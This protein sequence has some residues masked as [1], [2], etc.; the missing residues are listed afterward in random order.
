MSRCNFDGWLDM[1]GEVP[2]CLSVQTTV[3]H[4]AELIVAQTVANAHS[5]IVNFPVA[6]SRMTRL[7]NLQTH[8]VWRVSVFSRPYLNNSRAVVVVVVRPSSVTD[9]LWLNAAVAYW[10]SNDIYI[11][12]LG[13]FWRSAILATAG[14]LVLFL[15]LFFVCFCAP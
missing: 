11:I 10:L 8:R 15:S 7:S 2:R 1:I 4:E 9:V 6:F 14:L 12:D 5:R 3:R 13:W